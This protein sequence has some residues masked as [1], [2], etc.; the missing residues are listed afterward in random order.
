MINQPEKQLK[1]YEIPD[2]LLA[3][4][5]TLIERLPATKDVRSVL[6]AL[7]NCVTQQHEA[8]ALP[9]TNGG[10]GVG[11]EPPTKPK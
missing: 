5:V 4:A 9:S 10:G 3:A 7:E 6:N 2:G 1:S 8:G 11:E